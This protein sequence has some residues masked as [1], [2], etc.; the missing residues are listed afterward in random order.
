MSQVFGLEVTNGAPPADSL[1]I[2]AV[3]GMVK[4]LDVDGDVNYWSFNS[5]K[6]H[7]VESIGMTKALLIE[8]EADFQCGMYTWDPDDE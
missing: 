5:D 4:F 6:L 1:G 7:E 8:L 3:V 2:I